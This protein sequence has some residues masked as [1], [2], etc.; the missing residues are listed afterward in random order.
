[1]NSI[2]QLLYFAVIAIR[3]VCTCNKNT[4]SEITYG[5]NKLKKNLKNARFNPQAL[6]IKTYQQK[7]NPLNAV[8][9]EL[10]LTKKETLQ[11]EL[12]NKLPVVLRIFVVLL[13]CIL[14]WPGH[15]DGM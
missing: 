8:V 11:K 14:N 9:F 13:C 6:Y 5:E 7:Q 12:K 2:L 4:Y 15:L 10:E 1:M 3:S